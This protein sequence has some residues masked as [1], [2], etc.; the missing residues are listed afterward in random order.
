MDSR[1][2]WAPRVSLR[3]CDDDHPATERCEAA[4]RRLTRGFVSRMIPGR[5]DLRHPGVVRGIEEVDAP[6]G[7]ELI[8][9]QVDR[10]AVGC[11]RYLAGMHDFALVGDL[12]VKARH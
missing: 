5:P 7:I 6:L 1:R 2:E 9:A 4:S 12:Y 8:P 10:F 3:P 11:G